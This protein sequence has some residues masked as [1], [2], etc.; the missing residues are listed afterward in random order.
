MG[1]ENKENTPENEENN[2]ENE[3]NPENEKPE[4]NGE[5][6]KQ[7]NKKSELIDDIMANNPISV[8]NERDEP[9]R[10]F[11]KKDVIEEVSFSFLNLNEWLDAQFPSVPKV[12]KL[13]FEILF[14]TSAFLT[15]PFYTLYSEYKRDTLSILRNIFATKDQDVEPLIRYV[16]THIFLTISYIIY[17]IINAISENI[18]YLA[19]TILT[20]LRIPI[21]SRVV[22]FL[23]VIKAT[24]YYSSM[25][26]ICFII[27][28][29]YDKM[30]ETYVWSKKFLVNF[31]TTE[32]RRLEFRNRIW[33]INYKV[34]IF[35]KLV[36]ISMA[37]ASNRKDL[38]K[39][40]QL[41]FDP[42]FFLKHQDI[43]LNSEQNAKNV[44]ES[45]FGYLEIKK[46]TYDNIKEYFPTNH[47]EVYNYLCDK[48]F[49]END[50]RPDLSY[51]D[52]E[53]RA[54]TL[55]NERN[56]MLNTLNDRESIY[57]KLDFILVFICIYASLMILA[58]LLD[59]NYKV[60][61]TSVGP[62]IFSLSWIFSDTIK[63][64]YNCFVFLLIRHPYDGGDRVLVDDVEYQVQKIDLLVTTF[65]DLNNKIV[66]IPNP[67]LF[68]KKIDNIRRSNKQSDLVTIS[69][70]SISPI[71]ICQHLADLDTKELNDL[72]QCVQ[73]ASK[74][75]KPFGNDFTISLQDGPAAGQTV[76]HVHIHVIP[77]NMNDIENNDL[78]YAKGALDY[79]RRTRTFEEMAKEANFLRTILEKT[80]EEHNLGFMSSK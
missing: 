45:I 4:N 80:F 73:M 3:E 66:Y 16:T 76:N 70:S 72:F 19:V 9:D 55:A 39:D 61:L 38:G 25:S 28:I 23:Q 62:F 41:D 10:E 50:T 37:P 1:D 20:F 65:I 5:E 79:S 29:A 63:E 78:V 21:E 31:Y 15:L 75:L 51:D 32:I 24:S 22:E 71:R 64:I 47:D 67:T 14:V 59:I 53:H 43:K 40:Y 54:I 13:L 34:F 57:N 77:R 35:K 30:I 49:G 26:L 74:A 11:S 36:A 58:F 12:W 2:Q 18:L 8:P 69:A 48:K 27:F 60:Y 52:F 68:S 7:D 17:V 33:D 44:A 6:T 56:D 46:L 42:G